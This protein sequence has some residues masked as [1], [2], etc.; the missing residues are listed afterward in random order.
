MWTSQGGAFYQ[1]L[2]YHHKEI[3]TYSCPFQKY[4]LKMSGFAY[5]EHEHRE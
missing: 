2:M 1:R 4:T 3:G 5:Y